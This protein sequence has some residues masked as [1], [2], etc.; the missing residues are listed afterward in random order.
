M[1]ASQGWAVVMVRHRAAASDN[2]LL[3]RIWKDGWRLA[4]TGWDWP[5]PRCI[6]AF[7]AGHGGMAP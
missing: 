4:G 7:G 6:A 1:A 3:R 5:H 2:K